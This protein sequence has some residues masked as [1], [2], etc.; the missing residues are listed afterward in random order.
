MIV[1]LGAIK[2][3]KKNS[4]AGARVSWCEVSHRQFA[5]ISFDYDQ[6][7]EDNNVIIKLD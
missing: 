2:K 7:V 5:I 1:V 3:K 6:R 4:V